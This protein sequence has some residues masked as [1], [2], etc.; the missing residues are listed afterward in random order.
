MKSW[1]KRSLIDDGNELFNA[2]ITNVSLNFRDY[3]SLVLDIT[4]CGEG[5]GLV[6]GGH[7]LGKG[8]LDSKTFTGSSSGLEAIMIIMDVVGLEDLMDMK[9][10][11]VRV[12]NK[13]LGS[14][15]KIIGNIIKDIWFDY[16]SVFDYIEKTGEMNAERSFEALEKLM[17][18]STHS[19][20]EDVDPLFCRYNKG[21]ND[22]IEKV[23][24]LFT[25]ISKE[26][27]DE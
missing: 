1:T 17:K 4:L 24:K 22:A 25:A 7:V 18:P 9:G 3:G 8:Y 10:E 27:K 26:N 16:G 19:N 6:Y 5:N 14:S 23:E 12:A 20:P 21:R 2:E 15:V 11:Y 13:G